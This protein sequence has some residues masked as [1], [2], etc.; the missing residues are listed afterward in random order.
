MLTS[1]DQLEALNKITS[2]TEKLSQTQLE[3]WQLYSHID[4]WGFKIILL[5]FI[6]PLVLLYFV[7]DR[8]NI[9]LLGFYGMNIHIWF[10]YINIAGVRQGYYSY[11]FELLSFIPGNLAL[12]ATLIPVVFML[13]YQWT[14]KFKKNIYVSSFALSLLLAFV[15][16]PLLVGLNLFVLHKGVTYFHLFILYCIIFLISKLITNIFLKMQINPNY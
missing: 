2:M 9:L 10:S 14:I 3:Y 16:K 11:P 7:I 1:K 8:K 13:V 15:F 6:L 5:M 12:D 4:T